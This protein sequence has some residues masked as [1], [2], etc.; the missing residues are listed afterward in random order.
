MDKENN[1]KRVNLTVPKVD[2]DIVV[3]ELVKKGHY[4]GFNEYIRHLIK[5]DLKK[6]NLI[7]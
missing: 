2:Y 5:E 7:E 3:N 6:R 1:I 4:V